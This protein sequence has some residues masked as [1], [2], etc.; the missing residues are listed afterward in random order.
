MQYFKLIIIIL[1]LYVIMYYSSYVFYNI[2]YNILNT[3]LLLL[4]FIYSDNEIFFK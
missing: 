1:K 2:L 3:A 4:L